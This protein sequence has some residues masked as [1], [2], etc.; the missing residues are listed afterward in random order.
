MR[1]A[2]E[3]IAGLCRVRARDLLRTGSGDLGSVDP[4]KLL[5][6]IAGVES[7]FGLNSYPRHENG[8]CFNGRYF[9]PKATAEWGCLAH[10]SYGPWQVMFD[11]FPPTISPIGLL[12]QGD[13]SAAADASLQAAIGVLNQAIARGAR[14]LTDVVIAYNG[15]GD[16][17]E[18]AR[19][20]FG[21]ME[22]PLPQY[23]DRV[24][25]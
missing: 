11:H 1:V 6:G 25:A 7:T 17:P 3:I 22:R 2:P 10:C 12:V 21:A 24:I 23:E 9:D 15:P 18:Y 4:V 8:Y 14:N 5:W 19:R 13:G 16:V 20:L